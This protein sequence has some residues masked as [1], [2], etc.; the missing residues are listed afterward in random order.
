MNFSFINGWGK[1]TI[2]LPYSLSISFSKI[3]LLYIGLDTE[4]S[5]W[6]LSFGIFNFGI[7]IDFD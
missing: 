3:W 7:Q 4:G 1:D 5:Y 2:L 6:S